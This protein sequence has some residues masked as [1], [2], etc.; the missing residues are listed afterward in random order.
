MDKIIKC[1]KCLIIITKENKCPRMKRCKSCQNEIYKEYVKVQL[2]EKYKIF[3][4]TLKCTYCNKILNSENS[5]KN[6]PNCK[7]C[8]NQRRNAYKKA[9]KEK[10]ALANKKYYEI[11]KDKHLEYFKNHYKEN[12]EIYLNNNRKWRNKN[13]EY[14]RKKDNEKIKN[15]HIFKLLKN[16]RTRIWNVL[17]KNNNKKCDKTIKYLNCSIEFLKEWLKFNFTDEMTFENYGSFW[18]VDHVIPCAKFNLQ[19]DEEINQCFNWTN[20][21][22]LKAN[23]NMAKQDKL[24]VSEILN[25]YEKVFK[26][27]KEKNVET[28]YIDYKKYLEKK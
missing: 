2:S 28:I 22:P 20:L 7:E 24:I 23:V 14:I 3:D 27:A 9:N 13:R 10:I 6:R 12:K 4:G 16:C 26:F 18:H 19:D 21:Q 15:N 5:V 8:Y 25:H 17:K 1:D 11:N